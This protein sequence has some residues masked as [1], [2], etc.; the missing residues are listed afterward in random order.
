MARFGSAPGISASSE[1][2]TG[3]F[4][5]SSTDAL[6]AGRG[7][8]PERLGTY[9]RIEPVYR[10]LLPVHNEWISARRD[11]GAPWAAWEATARLA[12]L[13]GHSRG[14]SF[15]VYV[16][17][18]FQRLTS[19]EAGRLAGKVSDL[20]S[21]DLP[22]RESLVAR[23]PLAQVVSESRPR[24]FGVAAALVKPR[25]ELARAQLVRAEGL[26]D[27]VRR[28][29]PVGRAAV[30]GLGFPFIDEKSRSSVCSG[31]RT[32]HD[33]NCRACPSFQRA[34]ARGMAVPFLTSCA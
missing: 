30:I 27:V 12:V 5:R 34:Q 15:R 8:L 23:P 7:H 11:P 31:W 20:L 21:E 26:P 13:T 6:R 14:A 22:T 32:S 28:V 16:V 33:S 2:S 17:G 1:P 25:L 9:G 4:D 10:S 18:V 3:P 24:L 29:H 19:T